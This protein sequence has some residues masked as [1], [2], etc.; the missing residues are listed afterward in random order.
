[1][2]KLPFETLN[3][4]SLELKALEDI[5]VTLTTKFNVTIPDDLELSMGDFDL[6]NY[7]P[8]KTIGGILQLN[9][10]T[11]PCYLVFIKV[12]TVYYTRDGHADDYYNYRVYGCVKS[13]KD[14]GRILIRRE[15]FSDRIISIIHNIELD[16]EDDK[17]FNRKF[18]VCT[19]DEQKALLA[20]N[21]NFRNT[22]MN[23]KSEN[24]VIEAVNNVLIV[25]NNNLF[26]DEVVEQAN[27]ILSLASNC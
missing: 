11:N 20:M 13:K 21:W 7:H 16:F 12:H 17:P 10:P 25:G 5:Y 19:N 22:V 15:N 27:V 4:S 9:H 23:I 6:F 24:M 26:V 3:I 8:D 14:F 2:H 1:M 18:Y